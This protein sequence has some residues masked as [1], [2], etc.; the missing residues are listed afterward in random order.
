MDAVS[1]TKAW[2]E[3]VRGNVVSHTATKLIERF[4]CSESGGGDS[5]ALESQNSSADESVEFA[6]LPVWRQKRQRKGFRNRK[7]SHPAV[8][9]DRVQ[10][11]QEVPH[12]EIHMSGTF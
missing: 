6:G 10:W 12:V 11:T 9:P 7:M 8:F 1:W 4:H 3:Y 2:D 5:V